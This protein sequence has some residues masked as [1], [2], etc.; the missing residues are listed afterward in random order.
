MQESRFSEIKL[1]PRHSGMESVPLTLAWVNPAAFLAGVIFL[2]TV[3]L[4][5]LRD[6]S[7]PASCPVEN[8]ARQWRKGHWFAKFPFKTILLF[9]QWSRIYIDASKREFHRSNISWSS[10]VQFFYRKCIY[11]F[12]SEASCSIYLLPLA[13]VT[14]LPSIA[15]SQS[16]VKTQF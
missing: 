15:T 7:Q 16:Q 1:V 10:W 4:I 9:I 12:N 2:E 6:P 14:S 3:R 13:T 5:Q 8:L 11:N